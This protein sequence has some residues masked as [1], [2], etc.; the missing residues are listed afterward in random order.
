MQSPHGSGE[1]T[2]LLASVYLCIFM[3]R[4]LRP[5]PPFV[6]CQANSL[7]TF[8]KGH[9]ALVHH[10]RPETLLPKADFVRVSTARP[11]R[12][13]APFGGK[14]LEFL[15]PVD[16]MKKKKRLERQHA[17]LSRAAWTDILLQIIKVYVLGRINLKSFLKLPGMEPLAAAQEEEE[18]DPLGRRKAKAVT[19]PSLSNSNLYSVGE[20]VMLRWLSYHYNKIFPETPRVVVDFDRDLRDGTVLYALLLSHQPHLADE[21]RPLDGFHLLPVT[22]KEYIANAEKLLA[23]MEFMHIP[24]P[25]SAEELIGSGPL[26]GDN[27]GVRGAAKQECDGGR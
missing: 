14:V 15:T 16:T 10:V 9:G 13:G 8:L 20:A 4:P 18:Q 19:D 17:A 1:A 12:Y 21:G 25:F 6:P 22:S 5:L 26:L 27:V 3:F 2:I 24:T 7:L 23:A 11:G